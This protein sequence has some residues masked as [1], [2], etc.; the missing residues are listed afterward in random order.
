MFPDIDLT[1]NLTKRHLLIYLFIYLFTPYLYFILLYSHIYL[2]IYLPTSKLP[3]SVFIP[4]KLTGCGGPY[5]VFQ[6]FSFQNGTPTILPYIST[7]II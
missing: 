3:E 1:F 6:K 5:I 7:L 2:F 4:N